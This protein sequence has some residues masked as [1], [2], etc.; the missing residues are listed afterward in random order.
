[1]A[2]ADTGTGIAPDVLGHI[3]EP[4]FSTK[5]PSEGAGLGLAQVHGI[6]GQHDGHVTVQ[7]Q[8][9]EGTCFT[10]FLPALALMVAGGVDAKALTEMPRGHGQT[11]LVVEDDSALRSTIAELL[12]M[13]DYAVVQAANGA[14]ALTHLDAP[15]TPIKLIISD[16]VMPQ[17][18]G[19]GLFHAIRRKGLRIPVLL[20]TGH[21]LGD[22]IDNL[23]SLGLAGVLAKPPHADQLAAM[24]KDALQDNHA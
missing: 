10:I 2:V 22:E 1:L 4:F 17:L 15:S 8:P 11:V 24:I 5:D 20:M 6:V 3:F 23:R 18:G 7:S 21:P 19:V 13:W 16:V 14:D 9:G 12:G